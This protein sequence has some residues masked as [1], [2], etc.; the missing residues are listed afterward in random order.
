MNAEFFQAATFATALLGAVLGVINTCNSLDQ[1]KVKLLVRPAYG[2]PVPEGELL[3]SVEVINRSSFPVTISELGFTTEGKL[4]YFQ[5]E[6]II[7]GKSLP[8]RLESRETI[9]GY[10]AISSLNVEILDKAY[11]ATSC[12]EKSYGDSPALKQIRNNDYPR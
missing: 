11:A 10:F 7:G 5:P 8:I 4:R 1:R 3:V 6:F 2:I 9:T 12:G